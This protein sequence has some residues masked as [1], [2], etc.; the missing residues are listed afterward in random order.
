MSLSAAPTSAPTSAPTG[1]GQPDAA[2]RRCSRAFR[3]ALLAG[4]VAV[5]AS[6]ALAVTGRASAL[7]VTAAGVL[8]VLLGVPLT[9]MLVELTGLVRSAFGPEEDDLVHDARR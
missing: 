8:L 4:F 2:V 6:L 9:L 3:G 5:A 1:H 7:D